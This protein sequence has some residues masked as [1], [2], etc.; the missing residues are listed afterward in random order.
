MFKGF[1]LL[2]LALYLTMP[3]SFAQLA[4][5]KL[6]PCQVQE[7]FCVEYLSQGKKG[8]LPLPYPFIDTPVF[9][10]DIAIL[11]DNKIRQTSEVLFGD[12]LLIS[13]ADFSYS[14]KAILF[15][16]DMANNKVSTVAD[17]LYLE[18]GLEYFL[19]KEGMLVTTNTLSFINGNK[20][21]TIVHYYK[22]CDGQIKLSKNLKRRFSEES[23]I[24]N[25]LLDV[26]F[27]NSFFK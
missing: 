15:I 19:F 23:I 1:V 16:V 12:Y 27:F 2:S 5:A 10:D 6:I 14:S 26:K 7:G 4:S 22:L 17:E 25:K 9:V 21:E 3:Y 11:E 18:S 24:N 13:I 8:V 20:E